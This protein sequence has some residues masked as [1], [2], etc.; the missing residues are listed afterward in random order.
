MKKLFTTLACTLLACMTLIACGGN[1]HAATLTQNFKGDSGYVFQI[2]T[3]LSFKQVSGAVEVVAANG[4]TYTYPDT[5][6]ALFTK[7]INGSIGFYVNV[8]GTLEYMNTISPL[9]ILCYSGG[10]QTGFAYMGANPRFIPDSCALYNSIRA[11]AN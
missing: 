7:L 4:T 3:A 8:P 2:N 10:T 5:S 11:A 6:G 9:Y 1:A